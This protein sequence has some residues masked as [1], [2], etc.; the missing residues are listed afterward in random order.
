MVEQDPFME[1]V[2]GAVSR[3]IPL[4]GAPR[5]LV[6]L[7]WMFVLIGLQVVPFF[8]YGVAAIAFGFVTHLCLIWLQRKHPFASEVFIRVARGGNKPMVP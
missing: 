3:P 2:R 1:P 5:T 6:I 4:F 7:L 8:W